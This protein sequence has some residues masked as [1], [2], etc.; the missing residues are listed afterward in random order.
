MDA[1]NDW[2]FDITHYTEKEILAAFGLPVNASELEIKDKSDILIEEAKQQKANALVLFYQGLQ[3]RIF[4]IKNENDNTKDNENRGILY[5]YD[6]IEKPGPD[7][8]FHSK[9]KITYPLTNIKGDKNPL[10]REENHTLIL[11]DSKYRNINSKSTSDF[12]STLSNS[13]KNVIE[14][15]IYDINIPYSWYNYSYANGNTTL[16]IDEEVVEIPDG[17]YATILHLLAAIIN[18]SQKITPDTNLSDLFT[19]NSITIDDPGA[20]A[21]IKI[22]IISNQHKIK[23]ASNDGVSHIIT[24]YDITQ[25]CFVNSD[26]NNNLGKHIGFKKQSVTINCNKIVET[27]ETN[28]YFIELSTDTDEYIVS[29]FTA[30]V[31]GTKYL[32]LKVDDFTSNR[33]PSNL[34]TNIQSKTRCN[35]PT[36]FKNDLK[37]IQTGNNSHSIQITDDNQGYTQAQI[38]TMN[39]ILDERNS[40]TESKILGVESSNDIVCK[41]PIPDEDAL[42]NT[43]NKIFTE[44]GGYLSQFPRQFFGA[45]NISKIHSQLLDDKGRVVDLN[46]Q[47]WTYSLVVKHLYQY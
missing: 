20:T 9:N 27:I 35:Y 36:Y 14:Y 40:N 26:M 17:N 12:L 44:S 1:T 25:S 29:P 21:E 11:I 30:N 4:N 16:T 32:L 3:D 23:F 2:D 22:D 42:I 37:F 5:N 46:G 47:D 39:A 6:T 15:N 18:T 41:I 24:F 38:C 31:Y 7:A 45:V 19:E 43:P 33:P 8:T 34:I 13:I 10:Y 28:S